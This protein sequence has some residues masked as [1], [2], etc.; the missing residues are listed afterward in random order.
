[1]T[2]RRFSLSLLA[3]A[4]LALGSCGEDDQPDVGP[5]PATLAPADSPFYMEMVLRPEG[6]QRE[7]AEEALSKLLD[8]DDPGGF[9]TAALDEEFAEESDTDIDFTY[10][11]DVEPWLGERAGLFV[12][13]ASEDAEAAVA[14]ATTDPAASQE[15]I[16][17]A[18]QADDVE[19]HDA[20]Y[21][22]VD[23]R[24]DEDGDAFGIVG[25][26][27]VA[28]TEGAFQDAVDA[29]RGQAL[30]EVEAFESAVAAAPDDRVAFTYVDSPELVELATRAGELKPQ[31]LAGLEL[32]LGSALDSPI[33]GWAQVESDRLSLV[34]SAEADQSPPEESP[35]LRGFP[36]DSWYVQ[37][38]ADTGERLSEFIAALGRSGGQALSRISARLERQL[39]L[40]FEDLE[41]VGDTAAYVRGTSL[42]GFGGALVAETTDP[43]ASAR[44]LDAIRT[45]LE[46]EPDL[47]VESLPD[48]FSAALGG[49]PIQIHV[50]QR[51]GDVVAG[52]GEVS[53]EDAFSPE[54]TLGDSETFN[55]AADLL[56]EGA[57]VGAY[58]DLET[59]FE[60]IDNFAELEPDPD[61]DQARPYLEN[62]DFLIAGTRQEGDRD[63]FSV[64][65]GLREAPSEPATAAITP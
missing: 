27:V 61:Y 2:F 9:I 47:E 17:Q 22:G 59:L 12:D 60:L 57:A 30:A 6:D 34:F 39:G 49:T 18:A 26:F 65:L 64:V 32:Y 55:A 58:I 50:V 38:Q 29:S 19:E 44:A 48:G 41:W 36:A 31:Q 3:V 14:V 21:E 10:E 54:E 63:I 15:A 5:D 28:G 42:L 24:A 53:I 43:Q 35:M 13:S 25:D 40:R 46:K 4:G 1:V 52:L 20:S 45:R 16:D 51:E 37:G 33:S 23:Y 7:A 62:L 56:G 8:T 11:E